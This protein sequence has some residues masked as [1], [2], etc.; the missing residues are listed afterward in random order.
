VTGQLWVGF[1][2]TLAYYRNKIVKDLHIE[3]EAAKEET[4]RALMHPNNGDQANLAVV[5]QRARQLSRGR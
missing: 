2:N 3:Y 5:E 4:Y 1:T